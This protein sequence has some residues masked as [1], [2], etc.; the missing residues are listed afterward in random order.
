MGSVH[1]AQLERTARFGAQ[2]MHVLQVFDVSPDSG[3]LVVTRDGEFLP[4]TVAIENPLTERYE[5]ISKRRGH[6]LGLGERTW[7]FYFCDNEMLDLAYGAFLLQ[8]AGVGTHEEIVTIMRSLDLSEA[9]EYFNDIL[10][11]TINH[12][13]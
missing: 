13:V 6:A 12:Q 10:G 3:L 11:L 2:F 4:D 1:E 9:L 7:S 5:I 8:I